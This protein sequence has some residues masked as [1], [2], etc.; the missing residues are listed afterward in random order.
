MSDLILSTNATGIEKMRIPVT[1]N[2]E[3]A[4]AVKPGAGDLGAVAV[5]VP[6]SVDVTISGKEPFKVLE[7]KG[8]DAAVSVTPKTDGARLSHTL[9]VDLKAAAAGGLTREITIVTD[10]KDQPTIILPVSATVTK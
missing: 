9:K 10:S 3:A 8:G 2:V 1:V 4:I 6:K 7:V 5:G